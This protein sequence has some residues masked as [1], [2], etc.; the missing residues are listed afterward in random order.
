MDF[1]TPDAIQNIILGVMGN[2]LTSLIAHSG[3]KFKAYVLDEKFLQEMREKGHSLQGLLQN[4]AD[5]VAEEIEW[6]GPAKVEEVCLFLM[7][8]EVES[9]VRQIYS[10]KL[11]D[12]HS[13][14]E[15]I[16]QEFITAFSLYTG[17]DQ[18]SV[19]ASA[20]QLL[21]A[22]IAGCDYM[23]NDAIDQGILA[24]HEAK[25]SLRHH[26]LLD[27]LANIKENLIFLTAGQKPD[28]PAILEFEKKYRQQ[29]E[30]REAAI[31]RYSP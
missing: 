16:R 22:L 13:S 19:S 18:K 12:S 3:Q 2:G 27:E 30:A 8:P 24:A 6:N 23:L 20:K 21:D 15:L 11:L 25:S 26:L 31:C 14:I 7:S 4:A 10:T 28:V 29:V 5:S 9:I 1:L 17:L